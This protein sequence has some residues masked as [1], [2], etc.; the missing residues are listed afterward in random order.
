MACMIQLGV[1]E[2]I[3]TATSTA[4]R[5]PDNCLGT[6]LYAMLADRKKPITRLMQAIY[7]IMVIATTERCEIHS[8]M[9]GKKS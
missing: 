5:G 6:I 1:L 8:A 9:V 4:L 7:C 2:T 3:A